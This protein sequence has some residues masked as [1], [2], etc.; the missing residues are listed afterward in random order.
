MCFVTWFF[1]ELVA[2]LSLPAKAWAT[3]G[4]KE[5]AW[6]SDA[7]LPPRKFQP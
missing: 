1:L 3:L 2:L 7:S 4:R 5:V 6:R